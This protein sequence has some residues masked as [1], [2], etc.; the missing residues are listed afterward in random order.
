MHQIL[1]RFASDIESGLKYINFDKDYKNVRDG[2]YLIYLGEE[3]KRKAEYLAGVL[4]YPFKV[5]G[6]KDIVASLKDRKE[7]I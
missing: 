7:D 6:L 4:G 1:L 3:G 2:D 5:I